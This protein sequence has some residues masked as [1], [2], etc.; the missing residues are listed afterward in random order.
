MWI[1]QSQKFRVNDPKEV[2][3]EM[4][5]CFIVGGEGSYMIGIDL[6]VVFRRLSSARMRLREDELG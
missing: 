2:L 5:T 4:G 6:K 1:N 3:K